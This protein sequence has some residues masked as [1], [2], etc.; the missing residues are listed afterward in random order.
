MRRIFVVIH[1]WFGLFIAVFLAIAGLTGAIISWDHELD[2]WLNPQFY[3]AES[4]AAPIDSR[5]ALALV[6]QVERDNPQLRVT[7]VPLAT[8][9]GHVL[10]L[11]GA[12]RVDPKTG[13]PYEL[14]YNQL[15]VDPATGKVQARRMWGEVSLARENFLSFLYKLHYSLHLPESGGVDYGML[16]MGIVAIVWTLD[17][18]VALWLA[19][20]NRK[21]WRKSFAFRL[22]EGGHKLN[23]DLH[24][25]GGVWAWLVLLTLAVTAVS[26]NLGTQVVRPI[27]SMV[28][29]LSESPFDSRRPSTPDKP[30]EPRLGRGEIIARGIANAAAHDIEAPAGGL[31]YSPDFGV[32][33]V[34][35][36]PV[37]ND[38]GDGSLGNPWLYFDAGDGKLAGSVLPGQG[39]AGDL[40]MQAQFPLHSGRLFGVAGRVFVS[41][42]GLVV[43]MLSVTGIVI[44]ARKR[45]ARLRVEQRESALVGSPVE[46]TLEEGAA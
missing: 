10:S 13:Q 1:R 46:G 34:G 18:F 14:S 22:R 21:V 30:I 11:F 27:V 16:L 4:G 20:P 39:S 5:R 37:D 12:P 28:S 42:M 23:F 15:A 32:Y 44:W 45:R 8:E 31:F 36:F 19:F 40:F 41:L 9:P 25:S 35:F 2:E 17:C 3:R 43:A 26:M 7:Y 24:R 33:G 29:T 38:H 6:E